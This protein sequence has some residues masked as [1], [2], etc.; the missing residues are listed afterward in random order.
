VRLVPALVLL[1]AL[2]C[3]GFEPARPED[4]SVLLGRLPDETAPF[5]RLKVR[6]KIDNS[7]LAGVFLGVVVVRRGPEPAVRAQ[8]FPDLGGKVIDLLATPR[9]IVGYFP[10]QNEGIDL[11]LPDDS[12]IHPL[13]LVGI[14]ILEH[15]V[16]VTPARITGTREESDGRWFHLTAATPGVDLAIHSDAGRTVRRFIWA[17]GIQWKEVSTDRGSWV[18]G[19]GL[20][21]RIEILE[22]TYPDHLADSVFQLSLPPEVHRG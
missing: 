18:E 9:R 11:R 17:W 16:P 20:S 22:R 3:R 15:A 1:T 14:T 8:F 19:P 10:H 5:V 12:R 13:A 4:I 6:L 7:T 2:G 21:F